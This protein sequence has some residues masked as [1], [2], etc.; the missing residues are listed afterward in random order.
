M[1]EYVQYKNGDY[2]VGNGPRY[3]FNEKS[4]DGFLCIFAE[5]PTEQETEHI[6]K[7]FSIPQKY[8]K[9]FPTDY[10][11]IRYSFNPLI[12]SLTDYVLEPGDKIRVSHLLFVVKKNVLVMVVADKMPYYKSLFYE[13]IEAVKAKKMKSITYILYEFLHRDA[14][15]NYDVLESMDDRINKIEHDIIEGKKNDHDL[16]H[17]IISIK[18]YLISMNKRLWA[19]SKIIFTIKKDL[20]SLKLN[21]EEQALL[22]DIYDTLLHQIDMIETQKETVTDFLEIHMTTISNRL[23]VTSNE[24]NIV[25]KKMAALTIIIMVPTLIAGVYGMNFKHIPE[26]EWYYGYG[27]ALFLMVTSALITYLIFHKKKWI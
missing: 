5:N 2:L 9:K 26:L 19:S 20:T 27:L 23:A 1:I 10:R 25:M 12:F 15:E 21:R 16:L 7:E 17:D 13:I 8:F 18:R 11:S 3:K 6:G 24:L 14:K 22:D 4:K